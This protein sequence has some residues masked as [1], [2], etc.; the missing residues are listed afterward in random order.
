M[1]DDCGSLRPT[2]VEPR[3]HCV[4]IALQVRGRCVDSA[5]HPPLRA[6][7]AHALSAAQAIEPRPTHFARICA[8]NAPRT[9]NAA[10]VLCMGPRTLRGSAH[11]AWVRALCSPRT[12]RPMHWHLADNLGTK[13]PSFCKSHFHFRSPMKRALLCFQFHW[14]MS[15]GV[16]LIKNP[17]LVKKNDLSLNRLQAKNCLLN[18]YIG[19]YQ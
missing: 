13:W 16:Q 9:Q 15:A 17:A 11:F 3:L 18:G 10:S 5:A 12:L 6:I 8:L 19:V 4:G 14:Y 1:P 7:A 2:W